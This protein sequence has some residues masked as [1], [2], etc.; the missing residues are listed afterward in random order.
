MRLFARH[1][2]RAGLGKPM[3]EDNMLPSM[4]GASLA[5]SVQ[6]AYP[7]SLNRAKTHIPSTRISFC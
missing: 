3:N 1:N 6:R 7:K 2:G 4:H 5:I